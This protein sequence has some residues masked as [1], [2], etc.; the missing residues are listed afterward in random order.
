MAKGETGAAQGGSTLP[1]LL[2]LLVIWIVWG[3]TYLAIRVA[4]RPGAGFGPFWLGATRVVVAGVI[5]LAVAAVSGQRLRPRPRELVVLAV[6]GLLMWV[7][8]NGG[9]NWAEQ[10]VDSGLVALVV[11]TMPISVALVEAWLDQRRPSPLLL[12]SLLVGFAGLAVL[13]IPLLEDG[14][15]ASLAG[16]GVVLAATL[17]WGLGSI[18]VHRR[19]VGLAPVASSAWQQVFGGIGFTLVALAVGEAAPDPTP[20]AWLAWGYLVAFGSLLAFT[21]YVVALKLLPTSVVMTYTYVNPV[22][23]V[24]LG[25]LLLDES[26]TGWTVLATALILAGV[27]G[28][29]RSRARPRRAAPRP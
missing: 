27:A 2:S 15:G 4:V 12:G 13:T 20:A 18:L 3:S 16:I 1:G 26:V 25:W 21:C 14:V 11:G 28:V 10:Q 7:G 8:G 5:L 24:S 6:S 22:I 29:F 19:P 9:V 23:A 17:S